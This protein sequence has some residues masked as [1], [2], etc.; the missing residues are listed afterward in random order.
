MLEFL[1]SEFKSFLNSSLYILAIAA[2]LYYLLEPLYD[3]D[4]DETEAGE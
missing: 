3:E 4:K 2:T 1:I